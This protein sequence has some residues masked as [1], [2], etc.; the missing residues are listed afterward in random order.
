MDPF[1][2]IILAGLAALVIWIAVLGKFSGS[3]LE[4]LDW[5]SAG[6]IT[7]SRES[8]EAEDLAQMLEAHNARKRRRGETEETVEDLELKVMDEASEQNR[9]RERYLAN[10]E[11]DELLEA[12]NRRRRARGLPERTRDEARREFGG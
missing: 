4:Q 12:T 3:G 9:L 8:L 2:V 1:T 6:E 7:E 11:L 10:L 5:K